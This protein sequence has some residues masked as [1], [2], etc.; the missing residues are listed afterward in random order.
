MAKPSLF[1]SK[2]DGWL[3]PDRRTVE[4]VALQPKA[5]TPIATPTVS[6]SPYYNGLVSPDRLIITLGKGGLIDPHHLAL[7]RLQAR[8]YRHRAPRSL[9]F[10][11][12]TADRL[13]RQG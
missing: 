2:S 7:P 13:C 9:L 3:P 5:P 10:G 11:L 6:T 1:P 8:R 4:T 12:H